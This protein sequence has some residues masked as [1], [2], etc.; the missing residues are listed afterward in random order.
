MREIAHHV[1]TGVQIENKQNCNK[2]DLCASSY[3]SDIS[4]AI[5]VDGH[6]HL[7]HRSTAL[8]QIDAHSV[9]STIA[10]PVFSA[11]SDACRWD[12]KHA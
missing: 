1:N 6:F 11:I 3:L 2:N 9:A 8:R 10:R 12:I 4:E 7:A 5:A